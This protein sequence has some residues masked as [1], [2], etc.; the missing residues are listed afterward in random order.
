MTA[1]TFQTAYNEYRRR[2]DRNS[3][4]SWIRKAYKE[5]VRLWDATA[6]WAKNFIFIFCCSPYKICIIKIYKIFFVHKSNFIKN[7][8]FYKHK[9]S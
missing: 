6:S 8:R 7:R 3:S 5:C 9:T 2:I 1:V 4:D